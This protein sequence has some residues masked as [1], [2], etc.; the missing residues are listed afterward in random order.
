M[1]YPA[2]ACNLGSLA[3]QRPFQV[4]MLLSVVQ[5]SRGAL[6][7]GSYK[8]LRE[9]GANAQRLINVV[10]SRKG[11]GGPA[12][13]IPWLDQC[14]HGDLGDA[15]RRSIDGLQIQSPIEYRQRGKST[16]VDVVQIRVVLDDA[17]LH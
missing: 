9:P 15:K 6:A 10:L 14:R 7:H 11:A 16:L 3:G 8:S 2:D 17:L 4:E 12:S 13:K 5:I 1:R